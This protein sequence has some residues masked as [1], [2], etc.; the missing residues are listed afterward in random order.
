[1]TDITATYIETDYADGGRRDW[2]S[3]R[4][5]GFEPAEYALTSDGVLLDAD[6]A[7]MN[8]AGAAAQAIV[9]AIKASDN[10]AP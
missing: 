5:A 4:E 9:R 2:Y 1:M 7:P 8:G 3:V 6:G 10:P